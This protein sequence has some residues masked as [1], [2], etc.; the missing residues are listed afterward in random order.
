[1]SKNRKSVAGRL[2]YTFGTVFLMAV[3]TVCA[4]NFSQDSRIVNRPAVTASAE[5]TSS[6]A[7][8]PAKAEQSKPKQTKIEQSKTKQ[9]KPKDGSDSGTN[10]K[11]PV[12]SGEEP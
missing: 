6:K 12:K 8:N 5:L 10:G 2:Y 4:I 9:D 7:A 11:T 3:I 1:M